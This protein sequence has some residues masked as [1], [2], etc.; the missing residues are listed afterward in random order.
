MI[1]ETRKMSF[2]TDQLHTLLRRFKTQHAAE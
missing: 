1:H 2:Q